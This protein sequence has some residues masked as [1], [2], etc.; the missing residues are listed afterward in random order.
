MVN[1]KRF[2]QLLTLLRNSV[3][4]EMQVVKEEEV[5]QVCPVC[6]VKIDG[7]TALFS[8]GEPGSKERLYAR[9]CQYAR[10]P[11]CINSVKEVSE[12]DMEKHKYKP[13][14]Q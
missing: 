13:L 5:V 1:V 11:G 7:E 4:E 8:Y 3:K 12:A 9:V 2:R 10:K 6:K 14:S